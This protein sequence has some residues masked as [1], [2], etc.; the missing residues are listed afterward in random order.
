METTKNIHP[1]N[2]SLYA[3]I[4]ELGNSLIIDSS[5]FLRNENLEENLDKVVSKLD[6]FSSRL[7]RVEIENLNQED[8]CDIV[9]S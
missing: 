3:L 8:S 9:L 5:T 6:S 1:V 2:I 4:R 7:R